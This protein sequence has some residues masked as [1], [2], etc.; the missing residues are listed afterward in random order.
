MNGKPL[1]IDIQ[2]KALETN[3]HREERAFKCHKEI[4]KVLKKYDCKFV[5]QADPKVLVQAIVRDEKNYP[6]YP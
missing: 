6:K 4:A 3:K 2:G 5:V 1:L